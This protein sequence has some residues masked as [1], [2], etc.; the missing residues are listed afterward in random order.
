[1]I[2]LPILVSFL[3]PRFS[4]PVLDVTQITVS[5]LTLKRSVCLCVFVSSCPPLP[6]SALSGVSGNWIE[7]AYG[8]SSGA[9]RVIVQH[10]ET[11]GSGPQLFQTFTVHRSPVTKIMLSE[12]HLVSGEEGVTGRQTVSLLHCA[13]CYSPGC[14]P[15]IVILR[16]LSLCVPVCADN[17]HVRTWTV[18]RFRGMISTQPGSTPLASFKI[19]SLEETESHGSYGS[20]NDIGE[21]EDQK[22][23]EGRTDAFIRRKR[24]IVSY[25]H[26]KRGA[27]LT[28]VIAGGY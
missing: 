24:E 7:I 12:K 22:K 5:D 8:T 9:V 4:P 19:L 20:G 13:L 21:R 23:Y 27:G 28:L 18:T 2:F 1:M 16:C 14:R 25:W 6:L 10:P 17:N 11:V 15:G 3:L 26:W